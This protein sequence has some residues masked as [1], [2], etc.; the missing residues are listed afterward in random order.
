MRNRTGT[1]RITTLLLITAALILAV[2]CSE[3]EQPVEMPTEIDFITD[4]DS[5]LVLAEKNDKMVLLDF[6]A[7]WC[8]WCK[9]LDSVTFTDSAVIALTEDFVFAKID[10]DIDSTTADK[11]SIQGL[12]TTVIAN[13]DG[14]EIERIG[15]FREPDSFVIIVDNYLAG[16]GT[17]DYYLEQAETD[18]TVDVHYTLAEKYS[19]RGQ[20]EKALE[21][22]E[23]VMAADP[24]DT[25]GHAEEA[26][27]S[28]GAVKLRLEEFDA[29]IDQFREFLKKY[30]EGDIAE[31]S[32]IYLAYTLRKKGDTTAA[33][34]AY[35]DYLVMFPE[36]DDSTKIRETIEKLKNPPPPEEE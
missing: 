28:I 9:R 23:S 14:S 19:D 8:R 35:Q 20:Y 33:I 12:P 5:A 27:F 31:R 26:M 34:K 13:A 22:Y 24:E 17:L 3:K 7:T 15:G 16:I 29:A 1:T 32:Q 11:Y 36:S 4:Y 18:P 10:V 21:H 30:P 6:Y 25:S 2:A